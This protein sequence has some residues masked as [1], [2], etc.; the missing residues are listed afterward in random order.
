L[1]SRIFDPD[2]IVREAID[3]ILG[4]VETREKLI[5]SARD[6]AEKRKDESQVSVVKNFE[7]LM[8]DFLR[9][10]QPLLDRIRRYE[11]TL[12]DSISETKTHLASTKSMLQVTKNIEGTTPKSEELDREV[13]HLEKNIQG[14]TTTVDRI[15]KLLEK[16]K[17][18][19]SEASTPASDEDR[20]SH[21]RHK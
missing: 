20:T 15:K 16:I 12:H 9:F 14:K 1:D 7:T 17:P 19:E 2:Y 13:N 11:G 4:K 8:V 5:D 10:Y 21:H 18:Y 3:D 6:L